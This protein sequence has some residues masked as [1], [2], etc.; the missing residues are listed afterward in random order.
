[1][2]NK[3]IF[4]L[5]L[6]VFFV[7]IFYLNY[8]LPLKKDIVYL[9]DSIDSGKAELLNLDKKIKKREEK[10]LKWKNSVRDLDYIKE[11][12]IL[13]DRVILRFNIE[14]DLNALGI[15]PESEKISF[16]KIKG[17]NYRILDFEFS[18]KAL[19]ILFTLFKDIREKELLIGVISLKISSLLN[20]TAT[21]RIRGLVY[22]KD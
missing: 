1:M 17:S 8:Y 20:P 19:P 5:L 10:V 12:Y 3:S 9:K 16:R 7:I 15:I 13:K 6:I 14:K 11:H 18:T 2:K 4:I 22:E 21:I